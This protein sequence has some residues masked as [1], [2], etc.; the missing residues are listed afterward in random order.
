MTL[1]GR[2]LTGQYVVT[3]SGPGGYARGRW[4]PGPTEKITVSGS[5]QPKSARE[6][7]LPEEGNR[8]KQFWAFYTDARIVTGNPA[9]L[10]DADYVTING[11]QY[12]AMAPLQW[13]GTDLDYF[14][15]ILWREPQQA[16]DGTGAA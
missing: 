4:V 10:A 6:L 11:E 16:S 9:T 12:R 2:F 7:K 3:R 5:M 15:T 14:M 8:I 1:V 13:Q